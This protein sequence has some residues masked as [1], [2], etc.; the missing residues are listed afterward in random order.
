MKKLLLILLFVCGAITYLWIGNSIAQSFQ[1]LYA[2][3]V[4]FEYNG[5]GLI[6]QP[7]MGMGLFFLVIIILIFC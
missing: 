2:K 5:V 7:G 3:E 1:V 6:L 4:Q